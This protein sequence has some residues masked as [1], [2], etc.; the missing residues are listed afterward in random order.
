MAQ[1]RILY[2]SGSL[3]LAHAVR[4]VAIA[5]SLRDQCGVELHWLAGRTAADVLRD[6]GESILPEAD[7]YADVNIPAESV[8]GGLKLSLVDYLS[9]ARAQWGHNVEVLESVMDRYGF[10]MVVGDEAYDVAVALVKDPGLLKVPFVMIYDFLGLDPMTRNPLEWLK[11]YVWNF[12]W[13]QDH[14]LFG[15]GRNRALFVGEPED[16]PKKRFG[17][18]LPNR[19]S[20]AEKYYRFIG[21]VL[22]FDPPDYSD[23]AKVKQDLGYGEEPLIICSIGGTSIG[24]EIL[25]LCGKAFMP[26]K[27]RIPRL[28]MLL[29]CGPRLDP[30]SLDVPEGVEVVGYVP[31][32]HRHFAAADLAIVKA[33][34]TSTL[35]LT[36]LR[37]PF[38]YFPLEGHSEQRVVEER[39]ERHRAGVRLVYSETTPESLSQAIISSLGKQVD[40]VHPPI[41]GARRAAH[42]ICQILQP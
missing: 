39:L 10:D 18:L 2:I 31:N 17:P 11:A 34:G 42:D 28:R 30:E 8:A 5:R 19:R 32:L 26:T 23:R 29:V 16:V 33:G 40:Y 12:I 20:Y 41:D 15:E 4:D 27:E 9:R 22:P 6:A 21:Y 36:A 24:R 1:K 3:G 13:A 25:E 7:G 35:E 37:R 38:I 14:R